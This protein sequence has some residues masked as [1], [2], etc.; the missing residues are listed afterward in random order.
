M[1]STLY[2]PY[3]DDMIAM[4]SKEHVIL[5]MAAEFFFDSGVTRVHTGIGNIVLN[6]YVFTGLGD[7][8]SIDA[9]SEENTTTAS[10]LAL[11]LSG[12]NASLLSQALNENCV[13]REFNGYLLALNEDGTV[14]VADLVFKGFISENYAT[15]GDQ[16]SAI[17]F[18]VSNIFEKWDTGF[19][20]RFTDESHVARFPGDRIFRYVAQ[21][22]ERSIYWGSKKDAPPFTYS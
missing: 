1:A 13:N 21:M 7:L 8:G 6:G 20:Y 22:S 19:S 11:T 18:K 14:Q 15:L 17:S 3:S 4:L 5:A 16:D 10:S 12:L 9:I 2:S